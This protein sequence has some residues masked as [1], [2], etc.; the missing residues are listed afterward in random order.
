M[1]RRNKM[2]LKMKE[3]TM[4]KSDLMPGLSIVEICDKNR[5]LIE[6]HRGIIKY[7]S[8][9]VCVKVRFGCV[10]V[11]GSQLKLSRMSKKKLVITGRITGITLRGREG[12]NAV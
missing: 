12:N 4:M 2:M 9:E 6:N 8:D 11:S 10:C 3:N 1:E 7:S 5:V